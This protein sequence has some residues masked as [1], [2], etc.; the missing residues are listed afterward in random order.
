MVLNE[1]PTSP[2]PSQQSPLDIQ[3][4]LACPYPLRDLAAQYELRP[5]FTDMI[6]CV[7]PKARN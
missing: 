6:L 2:V 1:L 5:T 4:P 7:L 3:Q